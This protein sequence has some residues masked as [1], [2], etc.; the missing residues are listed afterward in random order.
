MPPP[1]V[2]PPESHVE[3]ACP[4]D[5]PDACTLRI[6]LRGGRIVRIDGSP[7]NEITRG[8]ICAKVRGFDKRVYGED[9]LLHPAQ[10]KGAKGAGTYRRSS[11]DEAL[12]LVAEKML[13]VR[14]QYGGEA[15]LPVSYGGSNGLLTQ[16]TTDAMLFRRIGA[17]RLLR[18][19]C[20]APTGAASQGLYGK[21]PSVTY[22]DYP[23]ARVIVIWGVNPGASG[24][25]LIPFINDARQR[26]A[27]LIVV[28][29]RMTSLAR[30]A[31]V[32]V[33]VKPGTDLA[34]ALALHRHLFETGHADEAFLQQH[35]EGAD[36]LRERAQPWTFER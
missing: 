29:P 8:Y 31:D 35:T 27:K 24:I 13:D 4:L 33:P 14:R 20:A 34:V 36:A 25:H 18:T 9:R 32:Y 16:D 19:V 7:N 22:Q 17:S 5:C 10:R 30:Q 3:T 21:M 23:E 1:A 26:G 12:D 28:D 15:I 11:W 6:T 2:A